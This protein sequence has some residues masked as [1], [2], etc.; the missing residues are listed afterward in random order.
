MTMRKGFAVKLMNVYGLTNRD[1]HIIKLVTSGLSNKEVAH[2]LFV[3]EKTIKFCL[4]NI[5]KKLDLK[6]RAQLIIRCLPN[7]KF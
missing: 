4:V 6:S 5:Y 1:I 2:Q 3:T 7:I